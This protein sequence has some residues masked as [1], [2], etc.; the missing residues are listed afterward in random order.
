MKVRFEKGFPALELTEMRI[1]L[2]TNEF[3]G[4]RTQNPHLKN[5]EPS[6]KGVYIA[7]Q[8]VYKDKKSKVPTVESWVFLND[9]GIPI[10]CAS[11]CKGDC[12]ACLNVA[13]ANCPCAHVAALGLDSE[14]ICKPDCEKTACEDENA[15][16]AHKK[17]VAMVNGLQTYALNV[18]TDKV[19]G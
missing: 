4:L 7:V 9:K 18:N 12:P 14:K 8:L 6:K 19:A 13:M 11:P 1:V 3:A 15:C 5:I 2:S 17:V 16:T 10:G